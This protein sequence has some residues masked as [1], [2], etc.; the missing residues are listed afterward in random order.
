M[1]HKIIYVIITMAIGVTIW[2]VI[3]AAVNRKNK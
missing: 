3:K 2:Q 1:L